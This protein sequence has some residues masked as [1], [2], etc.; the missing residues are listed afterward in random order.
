MSTLAIS[1]GAILSASAWTIGTY[2]ASVILRFGSNV[3]LSRLIAPETFGMLVVISAIRTGAELLSDIGL[4]QNIVNNPRGDQAAFYNTVWTLQVLRGLLL[5]GLCYAVAGPLAQLYGVP[6][7][8]IQF[9]ALTL[10]LLGLTST[11]VFLLQK[12]LRLPTLN[13]FDLVQDLIGTAAILLLVLWS[14]TVCRSCSAT[15]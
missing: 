11:S 13:L 8:A 1:R 6:E 9:G 12:R 3:L 4:G 7:A 15:S 14:P 5:F 2:A 10:A